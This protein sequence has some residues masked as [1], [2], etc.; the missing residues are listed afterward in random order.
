MSEINNPNNNSPN[1]AGSLPNFPTYADLTPG[2][3]TEFNLLEDTDSLVLNPE[4]Y[5]QYSALQPR[6][7]DLAEGSEDEANSMPT[8]TG[9]G[10]V[11]VEST[12][13]HLETKGSP[14]TSSALFA[15]HLAVKTGENVVVEWGQTRDIDES[16]NSVRRPIHTI[17]MNHYVEA[18]RVF[19]DEVQHPRHTEFNLKVLDAYQNGQISVEPGFELEPKDQLLAAHAAR[20]MVDDYRN[21]RFPYRQPEDRSQPPVNE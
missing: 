4:G 8:P 10:V 5:Q 11:R 21:K 7:E 14:I 12:A 16:G 19:P 6:Y 3:Q 17:N 15:G 9:E 13:Y 18:N 20:D 1:G 2:K